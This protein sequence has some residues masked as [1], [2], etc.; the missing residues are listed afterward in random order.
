LAGH[1]PALRLGP[2]W[3]FHDSLNGM[4]RYFEQVMETAGLYN[5]AGFND[6]TRAFPSI[7]ARHDLARRLDAN[8]LAGLVVRGIVGL[9]DA[10]EMIARHGVWPGEEGVQTGII[11]Y[12]LRRQSMAAK[13]IVVVGAGIAGLTAAYRLQQAGLAVRVLGAAP[14]VGGRMITIH[15]QDIRIDPGAEFVSGAEN[16][17]AGHGAAARDPGQAD[18]LQRGAGRL[19]GRRHAR[20]PGLHGQLHG[21]RCIFLTWRGS[22]YGARLSLIKLLPYLIRY[23][24]YDPYHPEAAPGDDSE[25]MEQFFYREDQRRAV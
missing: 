8:W 18:Q 20:G 25:T 9:D 13:N 11:C 24:R 16:V 15:W 14:H 3:W 4:A 23:G 7:P 1:Y 5:T 2:P 10:E 19:R 21:A 6:D 17:P 22:L 12:A